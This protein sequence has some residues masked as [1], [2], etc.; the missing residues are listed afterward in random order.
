MTSFLIS[1]L[2]RKFRGR[3]DAFLAA[4]SNCWLVWE[5]G[6]WKPPAKGGGTLTGIA[7]QTPPPSAG[8][9]LA[10]GLVSRADRPGQITVG[11]ASSCDLEINDATLSQL[12]LLLMAS[13]PGAW[14]VRDA[15]SKNGSWCDGIL[16]SP[17]QP[18]PLKSG[19]KIQAAQVCLTFLDP[20]GM[21]RRIETYAQAAPA[22]QRLVPL[23]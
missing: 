6:A 9:A 18:R 10:L 16:L 19:A 21:L 5:P 1:A 2:A 15:G 14:T 23:G 8:E 17:G 4:H 13:E 11:R 12:H 22:G 3:A 20:A 7:I